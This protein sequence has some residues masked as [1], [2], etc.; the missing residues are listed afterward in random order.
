[1]ITATNA[2]KRFEDI[3]AVDHI[4]AE[5]KDGSVYGLIGSNGAGKSTFLRMLAG[6]LQPDEGAVQIDG[7]DIFENIAMKERFFFISDEQ[8]FFPNSTP[9]GN[10]KLLQALLQQI[11]RSALP[12]AD[13][14][15]R[16]GRK[17]QAADV[18]Q[19]HEKAGFGHLRRMQ[20][21]RTTYSAMRRSTVSTRS[22]AR[23]SKSLFAE[24]VA[25]AEV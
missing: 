19:G 21:A 12:Q 18:L 16:S 14:R 13:E 8:F 24:D 20:R 1:M 9:E 11:R 22:F 6:I 2:T 5:V 4:C 23:R 15:L 7:A 17:P 3:T 10:E 25:E